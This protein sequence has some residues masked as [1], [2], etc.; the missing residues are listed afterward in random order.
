MIMLRSRL[1]PAALAALAAVLIAGCST[2]SPGFNGSDRTVTSSIAPRQM[3]RSAKERYSG[4][5][6]QDRTGYIVRRAQP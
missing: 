4:M 1:F 5:A 6:T 2:T 3:E